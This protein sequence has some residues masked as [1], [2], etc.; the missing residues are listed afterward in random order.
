MHDKDNLKLQSLKKLQRFK[1]KKAFKT[2]SLYLCVCLHSN[3][4]WFLTILF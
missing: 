1:S 2:A 3:V 4:Q